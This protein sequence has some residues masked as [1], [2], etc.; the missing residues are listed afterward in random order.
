M[1]N[2]FKPINTSFS[3]D[4]ILE[5]KEIVDAKILM[6]QV[7]GNQYSHIPPHLTY[8]IIPFPRKNFELGRK[9]LIA[10]IQEQ[11]PFK[12]RISDLEYEEK[13]K[14]FYVSLSG[15]MI[16][17]HHKN[18]TLILNKYRD[19]YI[20]EKDL[21]RLK[22]GSFDDISMKYLQ[23]YGYTRVFDNY[24]THITIGNYTIEN[25]DLKKLENR[26]R[27]ILEPILNK[28][29]EIN[30]IHGMF[31]TDSAKSQDDIEPIWEETFRLD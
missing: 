7:Y 9:D 14:F 13:N 21:E 30:N 19:N 12:A 20:R 1:K 29:I 4:S 5:I 25:V 23:D 15:D 3:V 31:Y 26:L 8:T 6:N 24:R 11:K 22:L 18:I 2:N 28:E 17:Q 16:K 10:Y 27:D